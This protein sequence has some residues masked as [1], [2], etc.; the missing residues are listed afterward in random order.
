MSAVPTTEVW[1]FSFSSLCWLC[2]TATF[3]H[4]QELI[5]LSFQYPS[6]Y[7]FSC[8]STQICWIGYSLYRFDPLVSCEFL[9]FKSLFPQYFS[10]K[11]HL[12]RSDSKY[13]CVFFLKIVSIILKTF[14]LLKSSVHWILSIL[15]QL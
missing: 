12:S 9:I 8:S 4:L 6:H 11:Y 7:L 10:K 15:P 13:V 3:Y 1:G 14:L 2:P 5:I